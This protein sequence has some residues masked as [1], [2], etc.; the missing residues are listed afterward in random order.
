M[1][2]KLGL[3]VAWVLGVIFGVLLITGLIAT[4]TGRPPDD[5]NEWAFPKPNP[6]TLDQSVVQG[7]LEEHYNRAP[8]SQDELDNLT[9]LVERGR[10]LQRHQPK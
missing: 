2:R 9:Q 7:W 6:M 1:S 3:L 8:L 10:M 5:P 4:A